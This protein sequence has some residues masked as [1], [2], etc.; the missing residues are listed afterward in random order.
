MDN[1]FLT[2]FVPPHDD[3]PGSG[4]RSP[5]RPKQVNIYL[6]NG[7]SVPRQWRKHF[8]GN[9]PN[10]AEF[11]GEGGLRSF[12]DFAGLYLFLKHIWFIFN[13]LRMILGFYTGGLRNRA[14]WEGEVQAKGGYP[15]FLVAYWPSHS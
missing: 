1:P 8:L 3:T 10:P 13:N 5:G 7:G 12:T 4:V 6:F 2:T 9:S 11:G 15:T 14:G